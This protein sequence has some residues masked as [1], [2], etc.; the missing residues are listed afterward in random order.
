MQRAGT[1]FKCRA[2]VLQIIG[3]LSPTI[4]N[5]R[6]PML[7][8]IKIDDVCGE[9]ALVAGIMSNGT[10]LTLSRKQVEEN[11]RDFSSMME[12]TTMSLLLSVTLELRFR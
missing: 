9:S 1:G 3:M 6:K 11:G 8:V 10:K 7:H 4:G 5:K 2:N 12:V